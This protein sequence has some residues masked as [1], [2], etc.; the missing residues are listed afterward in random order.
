M[1]EKMQLTNKKMDADIAVSGLKQIKPPALVYNVV[2]ELD[3]KIFKEVKADSHIQAEFYDAAGEV[4]KQVAKNIQ[5]KL[6]AFDNFAQQMRDKNAPESKIKEQMDGLDKS[7]K[8]DATDFAKQATQAVCD[9]VWKKYAQ[10]KSEYL[11]YQIKIVATIAG[12]SAALITSVAMMAATPFSGG[13][14]AALGI[15][16]MVQAS[17]VVAKEIASAAM[18]VETAIKLLEKQLQIVSVATKNIMTKKLNEYSAAVLS[19]FLGVSQT[20]L[21]QVEGQMDTVEKKLAGVEIKAHDVS[22]NLNKIL[23]MQAKLK[24]E[25]IAGVME[26]AKKYPSAKALQDAKTIEKRLDDYLASNYAAVQKAIDKIIDLNARVKASEAYLKTPMPKL[27]GK[28]IRAKAEELKN[29][30][31]VDEKL[32]VDLLAIGS[33]ALGAVSGNA[34]ATGAKDLAMG[35][36]PLA[37]NY[38]FSAI[39]SKALGGTFLEVGVV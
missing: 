11:K 35:L 17:V 15:I 34:I 36:G 12:G 4:Y 31:S 39:S 8:K 19:T 29:K 25:F 27:G 30:R 24:K 28:S 2:I 13:A 38:A 6:K 32:L 10:K 18:E 1:A 20:S 23:E 3:S 5:S 9:N 22:K 26:R 16:G 21:K 37:A 14:S 7:I 33:I